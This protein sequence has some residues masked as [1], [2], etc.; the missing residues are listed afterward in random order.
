MAFDDAKK[1][2]D[3]LQIKHKNWYHSGD[4]K[5]RRD[6][7]WS[8]WCGN[9]VEDMGADNRCHEPECDR[10][11][12]QEAIKRKM[13]I[14]LDNGTCLGNIE[15]LLVEPTFDVPT[16]YMPPE[17]DPMLCRC[18]GK[19]YKRPGFELCVACYLESRSKEH[20]KRRQKVQRPL[21]N[22]IKGLEKLKGKLKK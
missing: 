22:R 3:R 14:R 4:P 20:N 12:W 16:E 10:R 15:G 2:A 13:A 8:P 6:V 11:L 17:T 9:W 21:T 19:N 1:A 5:A 18:C 7:C